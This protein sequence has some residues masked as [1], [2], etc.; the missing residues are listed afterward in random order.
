[1]EENSRS[2]PTLLLRIFQRICFTVAIGGALGSIIAVVQGRS[3]WAGVA[4]VIA[5][6][7]LAMAALSWWARRFI[8]RA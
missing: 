4:A 6:Y 1:M 5:L 8:G 2:W 7:A 3:D